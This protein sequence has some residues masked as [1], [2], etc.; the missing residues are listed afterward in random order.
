M[1]PTDIRPGL[2]H[3]RG[4]HS[5]VRPTCGQ[6]SPYPTDRWQLRYIREDVDIGNNDACEWCQKYQSIHCDDHQ[7]IDKGIG[8]REL[9]YWMGV[10]EEVMCCVVGTTGKLNNEKRV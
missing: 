4:D 8:T 3:R 9:H 1:K 6:G 5:E 7:I 2:S 10:T